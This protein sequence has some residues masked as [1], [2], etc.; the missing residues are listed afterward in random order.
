MP[1]S[2]PN[3]LRRA[4]HLLL[5]PEELL[6]TLGEALR[7]AYDQRK[8]LIH[9]FEDFIL[10][11]RLVKAWGTG[12]Y[13]EVSRTTILWAVLAILYFLSPLDLIPDIFP[14]GYIDD[15]Y[16]ISFVAKRI[17]EDLTKFRAWQ[18]VQK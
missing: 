13:K 9:V 8:I 1:L 5:H 14:G 11:F 4:E 10:L 15:I 2:V 6:R 17:Q 18:K 12:E 16:V 3:M 7:K